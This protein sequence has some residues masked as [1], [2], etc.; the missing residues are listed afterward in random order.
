MGLYGFERDCLFIK[1]L[2][3][4]GHCLRKSLGWVEFAAA[5]TGGLMD[6]ANGRVMDEILGYA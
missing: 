6:Y 2:L 5:V 1:M 4:C 3:N